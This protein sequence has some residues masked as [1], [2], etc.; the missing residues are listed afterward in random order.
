MAW[1]SLKVGCVTGFDWS[2]KGAL[3]GLDPYLAWLDETGLERH[4]P[5]RNYQGC[6][7]VGLESP[8]AETVLGLVACKVIAVPQSYIDAMHRHPREG[9]F[10]CTAL[11]K[12]S[13]DVLGTL[14]RAKVRIDLGLPQLIPCEDEDAPVS[15]SRLDAS[16]PPLSAARNDVVI[17]I[18]DDGCAF[19]HSDFC[20]QGDDKVRHTRVEWL[21]DQGESALQSSRL[22]QTP[23]AFGYGRE[24]SNHQLDALMA[25][26]AEVSTAAVEELAYAR[27][28]H[29]LPHDR[30]SHGV[31]V[32][33]LAAGRSDFFTSAARADAAAAA[34]I[35][36]V[37]L[38]RAA[39][40]DTSAGWLSV[41]VQDALAYIFEKAGNRP[42][43]VNLSFGGQAGPHDGSSVLERAID[44]MLE[45]PNRAV[46]VAAG[47]GREMGCHA[48]VSLAGYGD[49]ASL[50]WWLER[51]DPSDSF[52]ELRV[53][54]DKDGKP[55][56]VEVRV[57]PFGQPVGNNWV[58][59]GTGR[60]WRQGGQS[61]SAVFN[62]SQDTDEEGGDPLLLV[63]VAPSLARP[64]DEV[65]KQVPF[66]PWT[67]DVRSIGPA[68]VT[69]DAWIERDDSPFGRRRLRQSRFQ[70][71]STSVEGTLSSIA[72]GFKTIVVGGCLLSDGSM[73][74]YSA[75]GPTRNQP[76]RE[77]VTLAAPSG[78][79]LKQD[80]IEVLGPRT[81][82][83]AFLDGTSMAAPLVTRRVAG[84]LAA[85][86]RPMVV[87]QI[88]SALT[89]LVQKAPANADVNEVGAGLLMP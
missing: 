61:L 72:T 66:G 79:T 53:Q 8:D 87:E 69:V 24:T 16:E 21:W 78:R 39:I 46:V 80:T 6:L 17:G 86:K 4:V 36:F 68:P 67:I 28:Q 1:D 51:D 29:H 3:A 41:H 37:Q 52:L 10:C 26:V 13:A 71:P 25:D 58:K 45:I 34:P 31:A 11:I 64:S 85:Q 83:Q 75:S 74:S 65:G 27:A 42:V 33:G 76:P 30:A 49:E 18:I 48:K 22:W 50:A 56:P 62:S 63:C 9:H 57:T 70:G 89:A 19:A 38:P 12:P 40:D 20:Y 2:A 88:R 77:G 32:M 7:P 81:A 23:P 15:V 54:R 60:V 82:T 43:V 44:R 73:A 5:L 14:K 59:P 55:V 35:V 47:N 84:I